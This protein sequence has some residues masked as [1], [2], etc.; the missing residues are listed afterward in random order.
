VARR[1]QNARLNTIALSRRTTYHGL[2]TTWQAPKR[3][4]YINPFSQLEAA[5]AGLEV[6]VV[7]V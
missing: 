1:D 2:M 3:A 4:G 6:G 5:L 7:A